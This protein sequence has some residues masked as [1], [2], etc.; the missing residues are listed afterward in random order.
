MSLCTLAIIVGRV[1][2]QSAPASSP[3]TAV[4]WRGDG[5]SHF[6]G[7]KP[8]MTWGRTH[9]GKSQNILWMSETPKYSGSSPVIVGDRLFI[10]STDYDLLCYDKNTGRI[11]WAR[12]ASPYDAA[13]ADDRAEFKDAFAQMDE[14]A[15]QRDAINDKL[16]TMDPTPLPAKEER[17]LLIVPEG[18]VALAGVEKWAIQA[19]IN[20]L[21]V[22]TDPER[23]R[24]GEKLD[25]EFASTTPAS[26]GRH[27]LIAN[28]SGV[29]ACYDLEGRRKWITQLTSIKGDQHHGF[30]SSPLVIGDKLIVYS[31][32]EYRAYDI[33]TGKVLWS[34]PGKEMPGLRYG[35]PVACRIG[36]EDCFASPGAVVYRAADGTP[37]VIPDKAG[38]AELWAGPVV[39]EGRLAWVQARAMSY[40]NWK[41]I[42]WCDLPTGLE[43]KIARP[44]AVRPEVP[45]EELA[46]AEWGATGKTLE[47]AQ[48]YLSFA[49][50]PLIHDGLLYVLMD[51]APVLLVYDMGSA[52]LVY[53]KLLDLKI[54]HVP[55]GP[56]GSGLLASPSLVDGKIFILGPANCMIAIAP[57]REYK[58]LAR[59]QIELTHKKNYEWVVANPVFE[60]RRVYLRADQFLYCIGE[61]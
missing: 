7:A 50:T 45:Y 56:Y 17:K 44:V 42:G 10:T 48:W 54:K 46:T 32:K 8:P 23:Y 14:L 37:A 28:G 29:V 52:K 61:K 58:E 38:I 12:T 49:S 59:N 15:A 43:D 26:D 53:K 11:L 55:F 57:G 1:A 9:D 33:A 21:L 34:T 25:G 36:G 19:K 31:F 13:T 60:G 6:P 5:T 24:R 27:V 47:Q 51:D 3:S 30:H 40:T 39:G 4:G 16:P 18:P 2:A 20:K 35:S 22:E 41:P